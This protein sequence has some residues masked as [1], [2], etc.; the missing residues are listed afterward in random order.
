MMHSFQVGRKPASILFTDL[1]LILTQTGSLGFALWNYDAPVYGQIVSA[2]PRSNG[3]LSYSRNLAL[4]T[5]RRLLVLQAGGKHFL[6]K[7]S[8]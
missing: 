1:D 8:R 3:L 4:P 7:T 6:S 2:Q 5:P